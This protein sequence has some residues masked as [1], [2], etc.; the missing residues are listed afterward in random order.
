MNLLRPT[1]RDLSVNGLRLH[2]LDWG[3]ERRTPLLLLH[4][5]TGHAHAWDTLSIALQ[6]YFHVY[7][8][9][10]R[11]HGDS[12]PA[13]VYNA[14]AAFDDIGG[15]VDQLGLRSLILMGL[16]MGG[17]NAIYFTSKRPE[18]VQKLVIVDIGPEISKRAASA[19][20]GPPEPATWESIEQA[21]QHLHRSNPYPGIHYYRWVVSTS[22]RQRADGSLVWA[23]HPSVK[24]RRSQ[25]DLDWWAVLRSITPPT[26]VLRGEHSTVLDRDVAERMAKELPHGRFV[27]IPNAVH[28]LHED[29]PEAV[30]TALKEFL[31]F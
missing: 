14:I 12:D 30:L 27:E 9:D 23:W 5:F 20:A 8:L 17:R 26:L 19:P 31:S 18:V 6:P 24:E 15:V 2:V 10:Q 22:L 11:G 1:D 29:N 13:E 25:L 16:S 21:A 7:A 4:G 28:T 3:G